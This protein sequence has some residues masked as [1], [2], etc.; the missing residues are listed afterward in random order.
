ML[1]DFATASENVLANVEKS[2]ANGCAVDKQR[3]SD[4]RSCGTECDCLILVPCASE[5]IAGDGTFERG[6]EYG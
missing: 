1:P 3:M 6:V 4:S 2:K 5:Y